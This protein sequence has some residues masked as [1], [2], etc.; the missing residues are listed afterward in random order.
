MTDALSIK[1]A[2]AGRKGGKAAHKGLRGFAANKARAAQ[3][4]RKGA[5]IGWERK[6]KSELDKFKLGYELLPGDPA[7]TKKRGKKK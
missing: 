7:L 1:R 6:K 2:E 4:G 3:A 5:K